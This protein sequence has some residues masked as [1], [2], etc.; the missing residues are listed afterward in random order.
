MP[1][2][3]EILHI[4]NQ[5]NERLAGKT[6]ADVIIR[7]EKCLNMPGEEF[8]SMTVGR[9]FMDVRARGKWLVARLEGE[10]YLLVSL[11]MGGDIIW[12]EPGEEYTGKYQYLFKLADGGSFH[13]AFWWFG[14]VHAADRESLPRHGMTAS[15]GPDPLG[16]DFTREKLRE[17][18]RAHV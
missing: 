7:Q 9:A 8:K 6:I 12:H 14:Y 2:L 10:H 3:P 16:G 17:I 11:G 1:E 4:S 15:L 13:I 18:G 5:M